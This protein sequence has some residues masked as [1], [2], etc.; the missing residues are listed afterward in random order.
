M[1]AEV[2]PTWRHGARQAHTATH[3]I[4]A[5]LREVLGPTAVQAGSMNKPGYLRFDFNY[6]DQLT[7]AQ[8]EEIA[9]ITNQAV[10]AD[11][12]VNTFETSLDEAKAMGAMALFG[13][14]YGD[15][16]RVVEIGGPFSIELC[17]G[18]HVDHSSQ[19][20]PVAVLGESSVGSG[21]RRIEAY[22][23]LDSFAY[24]S[25]EAAIANALAGEM[26]A[27]TEDLPERIAQLTER[28]R[29]AE[30]EIENLRKKE[31]ANKT[32]E[33]VN[34]AEEVGKFRYLA[35]K[36]PDGTNGGDMRTIATDLRGRFGDSA[37]VIVLAAGDG[38]KVP[39]AVAATK[40]SYENTCGDAKKL[41][42]KELLDTRNASY[43]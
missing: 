40:G 1:R 24:F 23:G 14:N 12:S 30:K 34:K 42:F 7:A 15:E 37:A 2:D 3:L 6:T 32:G 16:V 11:F 5:A 27:P 9:T 39:F 38:G 20:G 21:A 4:H 33:L 29:A 8:L 36:L 26:K 17:G 35:V 10:D 41:Q 25:K 13:E 19:I 28:L 31:L 18:T 22:S 43:R